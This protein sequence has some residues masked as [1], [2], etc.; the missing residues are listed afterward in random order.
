[1]AWNEWAEGSSLEP[2][3]EF[4]YAWLEAVRRVFR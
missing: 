2:D 4:G 3:E 1:N